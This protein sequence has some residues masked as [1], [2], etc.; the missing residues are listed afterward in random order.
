MNKKNNG[1][2]KIATEMLLKSAMKEYL[3]FFFSMTEKDPKEVA[4]LLMDNKYMGGIYKEIIE[5]VKGNVA[6][7]KRHLIDY[8]WVRMHM[9]TVVIKALS[10]LNMQI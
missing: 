1:F 2:N 10:L 5:K 9:E 6:K 8:E 7:N 4:G 3:M